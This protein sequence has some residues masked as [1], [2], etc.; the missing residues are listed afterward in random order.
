ME[1]KKKGDTRERTGGEKSWTAKMKNGQEIIIKRIMDKTNE[2]SNLAAFHYN[3]FGH[4]TV[5]Y[6]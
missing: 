4:L 1:K 3:V 5:F 2:E 6:I